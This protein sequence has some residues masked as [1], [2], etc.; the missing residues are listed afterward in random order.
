MPF[1]IPELSVWTYDD[2]FDLPDDGNRYE[3]L[4][5]EL[6]VTPPPAFGHE[7]V[8]TK[9]LVELIRWCEAHTDWTV[10]PRGGVYV[11]QTNWFE[12]DVVVYPAS[13]DGVT[14]WRALPVPVLVVEVLSPS[15]RKRDRHRKRPVYLAHGV[16]EV[17]TLDPT[18]LEIER[19][20]TA[21][22]FPEPMGDPI[23]W[24]PR[25]D[26]PPFELPLAAL[27]STR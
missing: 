3:I 16:P 12:P 17:W 11:S 24:V 22:E 5:G 10:L 8:G 15:T 2:L 19:W 20:T 9:L 23:R 13:G 1:A 27:P 6:L 25:P 26:V 21:S 7:R 18:T 4:H 14:D